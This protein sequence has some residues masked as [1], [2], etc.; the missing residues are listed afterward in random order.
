ME[1]AK[2]KKRW[3]YFRGSRSASW[4][5]FYINAAIYG[6]AFDFKDFSAVV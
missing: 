1:K 4:S 5:D 3:E 6:A 2:K